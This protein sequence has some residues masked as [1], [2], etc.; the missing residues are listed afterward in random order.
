M[1]P[2]SPDQ[3]ERTR[4]VDSQGGLHTRRLGVFDLPWHAAS[5]QREAGVRHLKFPPLGHSPP[6]RRY[7]T[8]SP[9]PVS[10][11][12]TP[13][14]FAGRQVSPPTGA[15]VRRE[16]AEG[17]W[18][19]AQLVRPEFRAFSAACDLRTSP[20]AGGLTLFCTGTCSLE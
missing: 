5:A 18:L 15:D 13:S 11:N 6:R 19:A 7:W 2:N 17:S 14:G 20:A 10:R 1:R 3:P 16:V 9:I 4:T 12:L 8:E